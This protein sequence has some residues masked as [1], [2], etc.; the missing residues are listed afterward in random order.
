MRF[1]CEE[2]YQRLR[3]FNIKKVEQYWVYADGFTP[4]V[5]ISSPQFVSKAIGQVVSTYQPKT[6][7]NDSL[8]H[9]IITE[10]QSEAH[11]AEAAFFFDTQ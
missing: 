4:S 3:N 1:N 8:Q 9:F 11:E 7:P 2:V 10:P 5:Q 6:V